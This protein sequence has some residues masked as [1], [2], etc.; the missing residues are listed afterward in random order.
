MPNNIHTAGW[1]VDSVRTGENGLSIIDGRVDGR[2]A[3]EG[4]FA[5]LE[6]LRE[7]DEL[8]IEMGDGKNYA[9]KFAQLQPS[10]PKNQP[11]FCLAKTLILLVN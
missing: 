8:M 3:N 10:T 4:V 7:G 5:N 6:K 1:F 9:I 11:T 2:A